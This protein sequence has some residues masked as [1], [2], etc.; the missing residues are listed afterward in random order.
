MGWKMRKD[1]LQSDQPDAEGTQDD[2][3]QE[4]EPEIEADAS[5]M[6]RLAQLS[7]ES[8]GS[9]FV[10]DLDKD[11]CRTDT[12]RTS[13]DPTEFA[14]FN[15]AQQAPARPEVRGS[16]PVR[17][18]A[19]S[20]GSAPVVPPPSEPPRAAP[21]VSQALAYEQPSFE[22]APF[23]PAPPPAYNRS[24]Y[25][26][27]D[28]PPPAFDQAP[29]FAEQRPAF[30]LGAPQA[31]PRAVAPAPP[32]D[33]PVQ[34]NGP[35]NSAAS[36]SPAALT[37]QSQPAW[38]EPA[39]QQPAW[40]QEPAVEAAPPPAFADPGPS[41]FADPGPSVFDAPFAP[42]NGRQASTPPPPAQQPAWA[43]DPA[44]FAPAA[45]DLGP[46]GSAPAATPAP[47][48]AT[49][50][51]A[52][53]PPAARPSNVGIEPAQPSAPYQSS[54]T[55]NP[56]ANQQAAPP[57][58]PYASQPNRPNGDGQNINSFSRDSVAAGLVA[59]EGDFSI[60][61]VAPFIVAGGVQAEE[62]VPTS[63]GDHYLILRI[64]NLSSSYKLTKDTTTIGRP[65]SITKNYPDVEIDL[66]DGVSRKHAE[67]RKKN[68][69]FYVV[70]LGS[71]NGT[72]LN[73]D[74]MDVNV[75]MKLA[76]GDRIRVGE[77]TEIV[78]E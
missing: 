41:A 53:A 66:D 75:E 11:T 56:Y 30:D 19:E 3:Y 67:I 62:V 8:D 13:L 27:P 47:V 15:D 33:E 50:P 23:T 12:K 28:F 5:A 54:S 37:P 16:T 18:A 10:L 42:Q 7:A 74:I 6:A 36:A 43:Q 35:Q 71:T 39:P 25:Q 38:A 68:G 78:F 52:A 21:P 60:P 24:D 64:R 77:K 70:D 76:H 14:W 59:G 58:A 51:P 17:P 55:Q 1:K 61:K 29:A 45:E 48:Q 2:E 26:Q 20:R 49:P 4:Q 69:E 65:D 40:A 32:I 31:A 44:P 22:P 73:G 46:F 9:A 34:W 72:L 57:P 63:T